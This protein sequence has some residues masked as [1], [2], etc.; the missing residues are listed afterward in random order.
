[1]GGDNSMNEDCEVY[2]IHPE[3]VRRAKASAIGDKALQRLSEIFKTLGDPTRLRILN[4]LSSGDM[5]VCDISSALDM[6]HSAISHQLRLLKD[7]RIVRLRKEGKIAYY[8]LDDEHVFALFRE[9][10]K[11]VNDDGER[12]R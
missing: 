11:Q 8:S 12:I 4:A 6:D 5:C 1:M 7:R 2:S 3:R 9:G 10:L